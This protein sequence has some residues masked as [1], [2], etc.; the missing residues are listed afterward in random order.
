MVKGISTEDLKFIKDS[1]WSVLPNAKI[2]AFGSRVRGGFKKYSDLD[3]GIESN[4]PI[5]FSEKSKL[6]EIF[7]ECDLVYSIDLVDMNSIKADFKDHIKKTG[8]LI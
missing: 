6:D 8:I 4:D 7:E 2:F 3:L 5:S 1:I